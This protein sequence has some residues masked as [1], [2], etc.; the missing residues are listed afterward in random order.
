MGRLVVVAVL[1]ALAL[2][3]CSH[4]KHAERDP[5][6]D[7]S[8]RIPKNQRLG[9][10]QQKMRPHMGQSEQSVIATLLSCKTGR[11][12]GRTTKYKCHVPYCE[13]RHPNAEVVVTFT[14]GI[15]VDWNVDDL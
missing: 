15:A 5:D 10:I 2:A 8:C 9:I 14:D 11:Q 6:H 12:R 3:G 1:G 4:S 13:T 7:E